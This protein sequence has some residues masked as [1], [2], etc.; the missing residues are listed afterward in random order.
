[1]TILNRHSMV[2][3]MLLFPYISLADNKTNTT[4]NVYGPVSNLCNPDNQ[5]KCYIGSNSGQTIDKRQALSLG[6]ISTKSECRKLA[7]ERVEQRWKELGSNCSATN[8]LLEDVS[9]WIND[10]GKKRNDSNEQCL[11]GYVD[12]LKNTLSL[13]VS[14][15]F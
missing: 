7:I 15:C 2:V 1:M 8:R 9:N 11:I 14:T 3:I 5:S 12:G 10:V 4:I 6:I 13:K